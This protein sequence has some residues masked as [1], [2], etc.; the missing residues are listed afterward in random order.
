MAKT[1]KDLRGRSL[2][3]GEVQRASDKRYMYTYTDPL[4]R[5]KF[6]YA[7]DLTQLREKEEKLLKD[8]L[9]GLDIYVAGKATLNETFDRYI[10]T[11]YNLR[12]STRSSYLYTYDHYVRETFGLKRIAEI[13]YSD[14]L[15]FYYHLLNQQ[16]ISLGTLDSVHCLLHPTFQLAVRDEIIRKNPTDGVMKEIS[17]ESGKNRGV[18]HALTIEQQRCFMEYI[19]NHPIYYHWWPMFTILLGT[20]CRI[21]EALGLRWQDLDFENRVISINHSLV[22]YPAN[23]SNKCVLRVSLPKTDAGIR[24]IPML[25]IVK[26]AFEML[27]EEQKENGFN[28]TEIDGM[29]GFIFCNRFGSVPNPQTVNHTIKRIANN[30]NADEVVRAKKE[31]R[32]PIILPNFSC[33]HLRHTFCTRLCENETNLKVIQSIMG[34]KNIE[35]TLDIYAEATEKKKQESFENLATKLD[36][37]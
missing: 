36:I 8:Q 31:H 5:R 11:K 20:G 23:G 34:H 9:D 30:Y 15:Q 18:R 6:I 24:T 14:V 1:R 7:N 28:E 12:E 22:Y 4:G 27:Y 21:G 3:K 13:K 19:A 35:T 16:G 2:R 33:H 37:F 17:R 32:D 10:S 29:S 25:D 26:D